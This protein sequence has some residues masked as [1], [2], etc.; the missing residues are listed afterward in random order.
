MQSLEVDG[1]NNT[2]VAEQ[3]KRRQTISLDRKL[4]D[5]RKVFIDMIAARAENG[6]DMY[7]VKLPDGIPKL[8]EFNYEKILTPL[9][10]ELKNLGF[11]VDGQQHRSGNAASSNSS[12]TYTMTIRW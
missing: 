2:N 7:E 9:V 5:L 6:F 11:Q 12:I 8:R 3:M 1:S 10:H 4:M